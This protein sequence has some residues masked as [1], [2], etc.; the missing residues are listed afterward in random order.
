[1]KANFFRASLIKTGAAASLLLLTGGMCLAQTVVNLSA[2][3]QSTLLPDGQTVPMWGYTC[4]PV[5]GTGASCTALSGSPQTGG[6]TW[7]PPLITVPA[8]QT[9]KITLTNNLSF[10]SGLNLVPTSITIDG[11]LGG[12]LGAAPT[13]M[14]SPTHGPQGT[15]WPGTTGDADAS[16]CAAGGYS[17]DKA[18]FCPPAQVRR[19]RSFGTEVTV[20]TP[21]DLCWGSTCSTP[22][23][24]A[25]LRPGTY[26]IRS[27]T[28][29]SI[30]G[31]MG[32]YGVLVVVDPAS[33]PS[34]PQAYGTTFDK[35][36][37]LLLSEIDQVQ[38]RAVDQAVNT[39]GFSDALG[40][41][42]QA[43]QC[44]DPVVHTC[45]PPAVNYPPLYYLVNGRSF[46]RTNAGAS[47]LAGPGA[48]AGTG[49]CCCAW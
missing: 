35:D 49:A 43:G 27:G 20:G 42:G 32:L 45:Y 25:D 44:G 3:P 7:Q 31:P 9:L 38:N 6:T 15:T 2:V 5:S 40:W 29:P 48:A 22:G 28:E 24:H 39:S 14:P 19:V 12:G 23:G 4:G 36:A 18:T 13:R 26:L 11:Q 1:M 17:P 30:R 8:G 16:N 37:A 10:N 47:A 33:T 34:T 41:N 21:V 46:D